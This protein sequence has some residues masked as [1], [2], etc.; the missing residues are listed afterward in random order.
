MEHR[1]AAAVDAHPQDVWNLF[2]DVERWP[3][4]TKS[5]EKVRRIDSGPVRVGSEAIVKQP[6]LPRARWKV[7]ELVPGHTFV[8]ETTSSGVTTSGGHVVEPY[9]NGAMITL[10]LRERGPL[11]WL[12]GGLLRRMTRRYLAMELEGFRRTAESERS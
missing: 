10:I 3:T 9:G 4:M 11:A 12:V 8:W 2:V 6:R 7:T 1:I 5:I